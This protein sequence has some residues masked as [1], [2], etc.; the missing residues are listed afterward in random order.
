MPLPVQYLLLRVLPRCP[1]DLIGGS[2]VLLGESC[3]S[4]LGQDRVERWRRARGGGELHGA[5]DDRWECCMGT[6]PAQ[7]SL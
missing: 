2:G 4:Q 5:D 3:I 6:S 1:Q 7:L